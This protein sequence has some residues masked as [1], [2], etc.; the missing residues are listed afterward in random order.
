MTTS[1]IA[2]DAQ[3]TPTV[4]TSDKA[5]LSRTWNSAFIL[6]GAW[7]CAFLF[8]FFL[9][10]LILNLRTDVFNF[11]AALWLSVVAETFIRFMEGIGANNSYPMSTMLFQLLLGLF[12]FVAAVLGVTMLGAD[13]ASPTFQSTWGTLHGPYLFDCP[14]T[15]CSRDGP[16]YT[17]MRDNWIN[18]VTKWS[19]GLPLSVCIVMRAWVYKIAGNMGGKK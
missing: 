9:T 13:Y 6:S 10:T 16:N 8:V 5:N 4:S 12:I 1:N 11:F 19:F 3:A 18:Y 15:L 7:T 17:R 14:N 2:P